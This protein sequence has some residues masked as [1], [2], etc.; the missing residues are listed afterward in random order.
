MI[1]HDRGALYTRGLPFFADFLSLL[2]CEHH[3]L[4]RGPVVSPARCY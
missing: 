1:R 4:A 3:G 2:Q